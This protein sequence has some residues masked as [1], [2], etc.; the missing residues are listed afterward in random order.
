MK[1]TIWNKFDRNNPTLFTNLR[2]TDLHLHSHYSDGTVY[3]KDL[4]YQAKK[5]G[6]TTISLTDHNA[7]GG[8]NTDSYLIAKKLDI[9]II[10]GAEIDCG[11]GLDIFVYDNNFFTP[12]T[13]FL[14]DIKT[15]TDEENR[16]RLRVAQKCIDNIVKSLE[17]KNSDWLNW[18]TW[19]NDKK[20]NFIQEFTVENLLRINLKTRGLEIKKRK[21]ISKTHILL[22]LVRLD[23][24]NVDKVCQFFQIDDQKLALKK[25]KK[26]VFKEFCRWDFDDSGID[27]KLICKLQQTGYKIV[28]AHQGK[29]FEDSKPQEV[30]I[31]LFEQFV[32]DIF[33]GYKLDGV[34]CQYRNYKEAPFDYNKLAFETLMNIS[35]K[36]EI[37]ITAGSDSHNGINRYTYEN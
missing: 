30:S 15:I 10:A 9:E 36:H 24:F 35:K 6:Y 19:D 32:K 21:F 5:F 20:Q 11:Q 27:E 17:T 1:K 3:F 7:I 37:I 14:L 12:E 29:A 8:Y 28:L 18:K 2:T 26:V 13:K 16:K 4:I 23:L 34:E 25:L 33:L 22:L 31:S